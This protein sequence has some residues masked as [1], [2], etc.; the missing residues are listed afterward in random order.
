MALFGEPKIILMTINGQFINKIDLE[1]L[2]FTIFPNELYSNEIIK[3]IGYNKIYCFDSANAFHSNESKFFY[4]QCTFEFKNKI[5][6]KLYAKGSFIVTGVKDE[7]IFKKI[8]NI[9]TKLIS[10]KRYLFTDNKL[11]LIYSNKDNRVQQH[12]ISLANYSV[13][14]TKYEFNKYK[15]MQL[16]SIM[17]KT[18]ELQI[19]SITDIFRFSSISVKFTNIN[20][21]IDFYKNK[22]I[23]SLQNVKQDYPLFISFFEKYR[24][25]M[26]GVPNDKLSTKYQFLVSII[27]KQDKKDLPNVN[28]LK[29]NKKSNIPL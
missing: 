12:K 25:N 7:I 26:I 2:S 19:E 14:L 1:M 29:F 18:D 15:I 8:I 3:F 22:V 16:P 17:D 6:V 24:L 10:K 5:T 11:S 13:Q 21:N 4:N 23:F 28:L 20:G 9:V 27:K